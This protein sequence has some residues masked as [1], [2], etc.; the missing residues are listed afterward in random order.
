MNK[1]SKNIT[2]LIL[3]ISDWVKKNSWLLHEN[4]FRCIGKNTYMDSPFT[5]RGE[6]YISIGDN[7]HCC[8][9]CRIQAWDSYEGEHYEPS[10][11][12]GNNVSINMDVDIACINKVA[13]GDGVQIASNVLITDHFHGY[14]D[15]TCAPAKLYQGSGINR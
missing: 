10:I 4:R 14:I 6:Q 1:I 9:G 11:S 2:I 7:F 5:I 13:I 12:I 8:R 3:R 15:K